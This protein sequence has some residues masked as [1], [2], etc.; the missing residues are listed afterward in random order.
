MILNIMSA[1]NR[2]YDI[3]F[4]KGRW[5]LGYLL[6]IKWS[7]VRFQSGAK[8]LVAQLVEHCRKALRARFYPSFVAE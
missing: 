5:I 4:L 8:A 1:K 7:L 2:F 6:L 3:M